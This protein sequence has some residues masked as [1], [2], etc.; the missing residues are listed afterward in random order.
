LARAF[1]RLD[2]GLIVA[3]AAAAKRNKERTAARMLRID[4][5]LTEKHELDPEGSSILSVQLAAVLQRT[6]VWRGHTRVRVVSVA[7]SPVA[8]DA[9]RERLV[10]F[11]KEYRYDVESAVVPLVDVAAAGAASGV[12]P[13]DDP[14]LV[15]ATIRSNCEHTCVVFMPMPPNIPFTRKEV[16]A[17]EDMTDAEYLERVARLSQDLPPTVLVAAAGNASFITTEI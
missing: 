12:D 11:L 13:L 3:F 10:R 7:R 15:N 14:A 17:E 8:E 2:K 1:D 9:E 4:V 6:D 5:W 16:A